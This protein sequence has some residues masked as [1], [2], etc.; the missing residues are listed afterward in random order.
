[1]MNGKMTRSLRGSTGRTSG[2][3]IA[4]SFAASFA[5]VISSSRP[6][7]TALSVQWLFPLRS[8]Q[9]VQFLHKRFN[10]LEVAIHRGESH[11]RHGIELAQARH[12]QRADLA[13]GDLALA[14]VGHGR[15][16]RVGQSLQCILRHRTL[17]AG[18]LQ[19]AHELL[20]VELL[21]P[22]VALHHLE[23]KRLDFLVAGEAAL[24]AR[25]LAA[26]ADDVAFAALPRVDDAIFTVS[27]ERAA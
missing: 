2:I 15:L 11:V 24:A 5:S 3:L 7:E 18:H 27:A 25:A 22:F 13:A 4:S 21:A 16:D 20:T 14:G 23:R 12:H 10:V 1:M 26:P 6:G 9:L 19:S 17:A 8:P